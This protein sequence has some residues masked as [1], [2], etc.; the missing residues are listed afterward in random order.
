MEAQLAAAHAA[1]ANREAVWRATVSRLRQDALGGRST[2]LPLRDAAGPNSSMAS[3][4]LNASLSFAAPA[5][6]ADGSSAGASMAPTLDDWLALRQQVLDLS[7]AH[8]QQKQVHPR[9]CCGS[10]DP[11]RLCFCCL[12]CV[13]HCF[14]F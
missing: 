14:S 7:T 4:V 6:P 8:A 12:L 2:E 10:L 5:R 13:V 11:G 1:Q 9:P 3:T